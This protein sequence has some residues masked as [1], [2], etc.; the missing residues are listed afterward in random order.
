MVMMF[1]FLEWRFTYRL[2]PFAF[3]ALSRI[4]NDGVAIA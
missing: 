2:Q 1:L 4:I 3:L